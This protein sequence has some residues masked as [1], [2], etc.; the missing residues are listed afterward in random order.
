MKTHTACAAIATM[1]LLSLLTA[2]MA[3]AQPPYA[4]S[5]GRAATSLRLRNMPYA[6]SL[7][8]SSRRKMN[9]DLFTHSPEVKPIS[10]R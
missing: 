8:S 7:R 4:R 5:A 6:F 10:N 1:L 2:N 3:A 9:K